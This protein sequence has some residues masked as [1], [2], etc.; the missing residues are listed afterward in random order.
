MTFNDCTTPAT[1]STTP[2]H[3]WSSVLHGIDHSETIPEQNDLTDNDRFKVEV[4]LPKN[5]VLHLQ[6]HKYTDP[7]C[8]IQ[9]GNI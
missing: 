4:D 6:N 7:K 3:Q 2:L 9:V 1:A 5:K 8:L